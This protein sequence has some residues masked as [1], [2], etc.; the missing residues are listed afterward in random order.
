MDTQRLGQV[1]ALLMERIAS[2][3][4]GDEWHVGDVIVVVE[5][6]SKDRCVIECECSD[7][8]EWVQNGLLRAGLD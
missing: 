2:R 4:A 8:R 7:D 6:D 3:Y 5:V 1:A